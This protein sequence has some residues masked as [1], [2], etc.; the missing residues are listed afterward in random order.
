MVGWEDTRKGGG[1][2]QEA[3]G[4]AGHKL[5]STWPTTSTKGYTAS[6]MCSK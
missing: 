3:R 1:G 2:G 5:G 6:Q 4:G